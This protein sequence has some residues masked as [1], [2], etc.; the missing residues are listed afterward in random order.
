MAV[1]VGYV[2]ATGRD[3]G[4]A[5]TGESTAINI[6]QIDP[7][8]ARARFPGPNGTWNAAALR[9]L[10]PNP[11][12]G[13]AGAGELA[14]QATIAQGQL[15][16]PYPEFGDILMIESTAGGRRQYNA[17]TLTLDRRVGSSGWGGRLSYTFSRTMDNQF[18]ES[19]VYQTRTPTPQNNYDLY[20]EYSVSNFDSPHRIILAPIFVFPSAGAKGTAK[21]LLLGGW[22]AS[23]VIEL[24][25]GAPLNS[26]LSQG[27][28]DAN[29]GLL[30]GRQRPNL[31]GYPNTSGSDQDRVSDALH[32]DARFFTAAAFTNPGAGT[33]GAAPRTDGDAR[34]QF[35]RNVDLVVAKQVPFA[36]SQSGEIR[37]EWV[38]LTN[39]PKFNG[40]DSNSI[41]SQAFGRITTQA[42]FMQIWQL[43]FRYRF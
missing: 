28:S 41:D 6:N 17:A 31:V 16:R 12:F 20:A 9:T 38:N 10:V 24:V 25:S 35:R 22:T 19:N 34:Y 7:A 1:T 39:T 3:I 15:L 5:G 8:V 18:G 26:V 43:S 23:S 2:G 40:I 27:A 42:G 13:V 30:G 21:H 14:S 32:P 29:L 33:Y 11:F 37:F 4:F 36:A